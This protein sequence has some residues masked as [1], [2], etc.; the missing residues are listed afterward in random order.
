MAGAAAA[1]A[2]ALALT[3]IQIVPAD[4]AVSAHPTTVQPH[5]TDAM[6]KLLAAASNMTAAKLPAAG[7]V[8]KVGP[9]PLAAAPSAAAPVV[10]TQNAASDWLTGAYQG[11]QAWVDWGVNYAT[12]L[13]YWA[14]WFVPFSGTIAAQTDIFY[15]TLIRPVS[16]NIFYQAVVPIVNDPLNLGVWVNGISNAV[17]YSVNDVINFGIAEFNYFFGWLI[18]P[19][20][21]LPPIGSLAATTPTLESIAKSV[22]TA[23]TSLAAAINPAKTSTKTDA[24]V[25]LTPTATQTQDPAEKP[26]ETPAGAEDKGKAAEKGTQAAGGAAGQQPTDPQAGEPKTDTKSDRTTETKGADPAGTDPKGTDP[27]VSDPKASGPQASDPKASGPTAGDTKASGPTAGDT[28]ASG[29][30][31]GAPTAGDTE[32]PTAQQD[33]VKPSKPVKTPGK[34][35]DDKTTE[36]KNTKDA[37]GQQTE[38]TGTTKPGKGDNVRGGK[39]TKTT[40]SGTGA[41]QNTGSDSHA[42]KG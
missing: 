38:S 41:G 5:L 7:V 25:K 10:G 29:P 19:I 40:P 31:A 30:K 42:I 28:K 27:K 34:K 21:P 14:G 8:P 2:T 13:L 3:P 16:D 39:G 11:I 20:P 35:A 17:R 6:V 33:G 1:T 24:A 36:V 32:G 12:D 37:A 23:L 26:A 15:W 22:Q 4:V 18:P 9:N